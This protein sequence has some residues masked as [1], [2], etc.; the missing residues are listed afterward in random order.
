MK[1]GSWSGSVFFR[2]KNKRVRIN[3][4]GGFHVAKKTRSMAI[5]RKCLECSGDRPKEVV[6]CPVKDCPLYPYRFGFD[7]GSKRYLNKIKRAYTQWP[8]ESAD[9]DIQ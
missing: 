9:L 6:L 1:N 7:P 8:K 4:H 3:F 2:K 5:K